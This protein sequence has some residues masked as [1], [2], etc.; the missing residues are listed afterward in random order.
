MTLKIQKNRLLSTDFQDKTKGKQKSG[1]QL[2]KGWIGRIKNLFKSTFSVYV[3]GKK[4]WVNRKS[5]EKYLVRNYKTFNFET[6]NAIKEKIKL[7]KI[8]NLF[9]YLV[10]PESSPRLYELSTLKVGVQMAGVTIDVDSGEQI[11]VHPI[12]EKFK[13]VKVRFDPTK[14]TPSTVSQKVFKKLGFKNIHV[15]LKIG[16]S[17]SYKTSFN[18]CSDGPLLGRED[19]SKLLTTLNPKSLCLWALVYDD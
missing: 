5:A 17:L 7:E 9:H 1:V 11:K 2:N 4:Y 15:V 14:D 18:S 13:F 10:A 12:Q 8:D 16:G 19:A 6:K 3:D